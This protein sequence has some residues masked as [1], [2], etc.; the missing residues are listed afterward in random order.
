MNRCFKNRFFTEI[1]SEAGFTLVEMLVAMTIASVFFAS[2]TAVVIATVQTL[3]TGDQRTVAQ[4][5]ARIAANFLSDEIKQMSELEPP[6]FSEY[7]DQRTNSIPRNGECVLNSIGT[8]VY[9]VIRQSTD[10]SARG[11]ID[12]NHADASAGIDEYEDFRDDGMPYDIRPLFPNKINFLLNQS[13]Y[14]P[15]TVYSTLN[16][17]VPG[18]AIYL[19]GESFDLL[20]NSDNSQAADI[21]IT[22]EHQKQPPRWGLIPDEGLLKDLYLPI[23]SSSGGGVNLFGKPF[24]LLRSFQI[25]NVTGTGRN[26]WGFNE[27]VSVPYNLVDPDGIDSG[28]DLTRPSDDLRQIVADHIVD[29]RF[30]YFHIRAGQ[31]IEIRYDPYTEHTASSGGGTAVTTNDGYYRYFDQYGQEIFIW[32]T[33]DE[34]ELELPDPNLTMMEIVE[35]WR[36]Q[37]PRL[38]TFMPVNEFER[39]LFLF[40]G[41]RFVNAVMITIKAANPELQQDYFSS[42]VNDDTL[43]DKNEPDF[44][45]GFVDFQKGG[46]YQDGLNVVDP[47][48]HALDSYRE[49]M[50]IDNTVTIYPDGNDGPFDFVDPNGNAA[51]D[52]GRFVTL[53]TIVSPPILYSTS[54][55]A[56][57]QLTFGL[58]FI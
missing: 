40:E 38:W 37:S 51:F 23:F 15:H 9:P 22:Y 30:R 25:E 48:W 2:F 17:L 11:Y 55:E 5:N 7:R 4:Q 41:W 54:R 26:D 35:H 34:D 28:I 47:L 36:D 14:L 12:L 20:N 45:L 58:S 27:T 43:I 6:Q 44:G 31:S 42:T 18:G 19:D 21:R 13:T 46:S 49:G 33:P 53:Q 52:P 24:V 1:V 50:K 32:A 10:G 57:S 29:I 56:A 16:P 3:K 8:E 39:G